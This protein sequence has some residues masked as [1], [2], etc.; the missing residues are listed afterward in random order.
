MNMKNICTYN[1]FIN[2]LNLIQCDG[3]TARRNAL[4][5][6]KFDIC[7]IVAKCIADPLNANLLKHV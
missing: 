6:R 7:I 2:R 3:R 1:N 4:Q 5:N